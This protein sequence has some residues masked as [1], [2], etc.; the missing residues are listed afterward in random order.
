MN[1]IHTTIISFSGADFITADGMVLEPADR[2]P[3]PGTKDPY[4]GAQIEYE[5]SE[6]KVSW[7]TVELDMPSPE[8]ELSVLIEIRDLLTKIEANTHTHG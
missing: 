7:R 8:T 4:V 2:V 5:I 6:G 1:Q 3:A